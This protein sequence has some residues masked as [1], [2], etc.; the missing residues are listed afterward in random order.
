M[1]SPPDDTRLVLEAPAKIN[2]YL[3]VAGRRP[4]GF[5]ELVTVLQT[6]DLADRVEVSMRPRR[7]SVPPGAP[8]VAFT[9]E[10]DAPSGDDPPAGDAS[11]SG[12]A[13]VVPAD[14]DNLVVR[15]AVAWLTAADLVDRTG[16]DLVLR[17]RIPAG[18]G[19]G[20]GSSDA[21]T[22]LLAL[23]RLRTAAGVD[24]PGPDLQPLAA[25][26]GSDVPFF[27]VGGTALCTGRGEHVVPIAEPEPFDLL[28]AFPGFPVPTPAVYG[29]L[30]AP[31][32]PAQHARDLPARISAWADRL[33]GADVARLDALYRNDLED[34]A[35]R[36]RSELVDLLSAPDIHLSGSGSTLFLY[37][38]QPPSP[39]SACRHASMRFVRH[40]SRKR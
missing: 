37:G 26:L 8:D 13:S 6:I 33:A 11:P 2:L 20:G 15:A 9:L 21:A 30:D 19:L 25:A 27:L 12:D 22:V 18:A 29:A 35:R 28:L 34:P 36:V 14:A 17:K 16:V 10:R 39:R 31:A 1:S 23:D 32:L 5:H 38:S 3:E 7:A 40:R 24:G 4:D